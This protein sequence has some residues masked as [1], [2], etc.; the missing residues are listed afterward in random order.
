MSMLPPSHP[1]A[2]LLKDCS[3]IFLKI[4]FNKHENISLIYIISS[5]ERKIIIKKLALSVSFSGFDKLL[6]ESRKSERAR[7]K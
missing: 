1:N 5:Q 2:S 7:K 4:F 6:A 3:T